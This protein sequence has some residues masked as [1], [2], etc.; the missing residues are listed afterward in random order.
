MDSNPP[1]YFYLV[2]FYTLHNMI[3]QKVAE[4]ARAIFTG[5]NLPVVINLTKPVDGFAALSIQSHLP[6]EDHRIAKFQ[7]Y[8]LKMEDL[9]L[10]FAQATS[11]VDEVAEP[12]PPTYVLSGFF[13]LNFSLLE[14]YFGAGRTFLRQLTRHIKAIPQGAYFLQS[15]RS[16]LGLSLESTQPYSPDDMAKLLQ[17]LN[18]PKVSQKTLY[19]NY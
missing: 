9:E 1:P 18:H 3:L 2:H 11:D 17:I 7:S 12:Y 14:L 16:D 15:S 6:I 10:I 4:L 19:Q 8:L 13:L 5:D